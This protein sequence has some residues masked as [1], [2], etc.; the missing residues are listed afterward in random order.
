MVK[1]NLLKTGTSWATPVAIAGRKLAI[2]LAISAVPPSDE[3]DNLL[4][5]SRDSP[6]GPDETA[7]EHIH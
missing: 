6:A 3:A 5:H 2:D 7:R 4:M 1:V